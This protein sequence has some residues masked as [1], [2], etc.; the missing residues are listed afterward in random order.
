MFAAQRSSGRLPVSL[1]TFFFGAAECY[2]KIGKVCLGGSVHFADEFL[3][4]LAAL[5]KVGEI[6]HCHF[7]E[8][9]GKQGLPQGFQAFRRA[10]EDG[11]R[12]LDDAE[13]QVSALIG[14]VRTHNLGQLFAQGDALSQQLTCHLNADCFQIAVRRDAF[15]LHKGTQQG[16]FAQTCAAAELFQ[17]E[18]FGIVLPDKG[19]DRFHFLRGG[20]NAVH[21]G[22]AAALQQCGKQIE[23]EFFFLK[24]GIAPQ[25]QFVQGAQAVGQHIIPQDIL[26]KA[27]QRAGA[28]DLFG[29]SEH[30][31]LRDVEGPVGKG[32][33]IALGA[34]VAVAGVEQQNVTRPQGIFPIFAAESA[35][36]CLD[37]AQ[38]IVL[39]EM[40][41][42]GLHD[43]RKAVGFQTQLPVV[44]HGAQFGG[45]HSGT[46]PFQRHCSA[47]NAG[48]LVRYRQISRRARSSA[49]DGHA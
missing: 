4:G 28:G 13:V 14:H 38:H 19:T 49:W 15:C 18:M 12:E 40:V 7:L 3:I 2:S 47:K 24:T 41:R 31:I 16:R 48:S 43:A 21:G 32:A 45:L 27:G 22:R 23:Q 39:V 42:E 29:K 30:G 5:G 6:H 8:L 10:F 37:Q 34:A 25:H 35:P 26:R 36:A 46:P 33:A 9:R 17:I 1:F 20:W 44:Y 11:H